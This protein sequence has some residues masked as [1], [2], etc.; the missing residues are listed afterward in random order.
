MALAASIPVARAAA[1][2]PSKSASSPPCA[3]ESAFPLAFWPAS[4][5]PRSCLLLNLLPLWQLDA[6]ELLRIMTGLPAKR[7]AA[8]LASVGST[9][10]SAIEP[11]P[12]IADIAERHNVWLHVDAAYGGSAAVL[13]EFRHILNGANAL[14]H[15]SSIRTNG[16]MLVLI[17]A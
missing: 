7:P 4:S 16:S 3:V 2:L 10:T 17:A 5:L 14:T 11:V 1:P 9:G 8:I 15:S 13:P 12:A 6:L